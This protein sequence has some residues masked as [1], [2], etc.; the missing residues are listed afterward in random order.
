MAI[1][2]GATSAASA[3]VVVKYEYVDHPTNYLPSNQGWTGPNPSVD[4]D[5]NDGVV[6]RSNNSVDAALELGDTDDVVGP[7]VTANIG[8]ADYAGDWTLTVRVRL[9]SA[10]S[11]ASYVFGVATGNYLWNIWLDPAGKLHSYDSNGPSGPNIYEKV[12]GLNMSQFHTYKLVGSG[13]NAPE[14]WVDG[15][16][17]NIY[18][19]GATSTSQSVDWGAIWSGGTEGVSNWQ[20]VRFD[21]GFLDVPEPASLGLLSAGAMLLLRKRR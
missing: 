11:I 8:P 16:E 15:V 21:T 19:G 7:A 17:T 2:A 5:G 18:A 13:A 6:S 10:N 1:V 9:D 14:I 3:A 12:T 4:V 20:V